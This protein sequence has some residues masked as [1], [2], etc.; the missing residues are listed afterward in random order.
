VA[1]TRARA[2]LLSSAQDGE[3]MA[4]DARKEEQLEVRA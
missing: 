1:L 2:R 3:R 4:A